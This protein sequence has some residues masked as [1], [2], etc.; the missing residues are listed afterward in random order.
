LKN[1]WGGVR[2]GAGRKPTGRIRRSF[3]L[4]AEEFERMK[5]YLKWL[6]EVK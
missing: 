3:Y 6:R 5:A 2:A 4:T 1:E